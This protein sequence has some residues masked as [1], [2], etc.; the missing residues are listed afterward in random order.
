M[1][2][3]M[4]YIRKRECYRAG[5]RTCFTRDDF[6]GPK[7]QLYIQYTDGTEQDRGGMD[8]ECDPPYFRSLLEDDDESKWKKN[9]NCLFLA[10]CHKIRI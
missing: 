9:D 6:S 7:G 2:A 5:G 1:I 8:E 10:D 4:F 3:R